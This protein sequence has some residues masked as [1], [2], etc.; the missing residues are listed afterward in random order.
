MQRVFTEGLAQASFVVASDATRQAIVIDPRRDVAVYLAIAAAHDLQIAHIYET[1]IHADYASGARELAAR[2]GAVMHLSAIGESEFEHEP[3]HDGDVL[4]VGELRVQALLTPGHTPEH[5]CLLVT[6]TAHP[7]DPATLFSGDA[8][9]VGSVGRPDLLGAEQTK[10][11]ATALY[12]TIHDTLMTL[13]DEIIVYPGHG[14]GSACGKA[15]GNDPSTTM[16]QEKRFNFA[17][18]PAN[19]EQFV[20]MILDGLPEPPPYFPV[21]K[22]LNKQG[23]QILGGIPSPDSLSTD[24]LRRAQQGETTIVDVRPAE[25]FG[26]GFLAGS[27]NIGLGPS[28]PNWAGWAVSYERPIVLVVADAADVEEAVTWLI[29]IGL[30]NVTGYAVADPDGWRAA[31]LAVE[32]IEQID[33]R[34]ANARLA[35]GDLQLLD[36]RNIDEW[37]GGHVSGAHNVP[38]GP[39]VRGADGLDPNRPVAVMCAAGYRSSLGA[40]ALKQR[41]YDDVI[42][43]A[44]GMDAWR[45]AG[46]PVDA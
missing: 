2:T 36:V 7:A 22:R 44:G 45:A 15:I 20:E 46:L 23:P 8:V 31:G 24:D 12:Q 40:S 25:R 35:A 16:G 41:G 18:Q 13:D 17:F 19:E 9:F 11:L 21:M 26:E 32:R 27:L 5:I 10:A 38:V 33:P 6:D 28:L 4:A 3:V 1:H 34:T 37:N 30:D 42:N 43:V 29:R 39:L 14:A